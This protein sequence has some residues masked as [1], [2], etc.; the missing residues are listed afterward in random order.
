MPL[1]S[2]QEPEGQREP[3][4]VAGGRTADCRGRA[5]RAEWQ[6]LAVAS[7]RGGPRSPAR[8]PTPGSPD[9]RSGCGTTFPGLLGMGHKP[10]T[11]TRPGGRPLSFWQDPLGLAGWA[12]REGSTF[13]HHRKGDPEPPPVARGPKGPPHLVPSQP[14]GRL[15]VQPGV[16]ACVAASRSPRRSCRRQR[17]HL[18]PRCHH[19]VQEVARPSFRRGG[20]RRGQGGEIRLGSHQRPGGK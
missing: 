7:I 20:E 4:W 11:P 9:R 2:P 13:T 1:P 8:S 3:F 5:P 16:H 6:E 19:Q 18:Q 12:V 14:L 10:A 17:R 15:L